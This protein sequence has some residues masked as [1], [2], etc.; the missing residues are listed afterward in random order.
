MAAIA[1][2]S[3][4]TASYSG[5]FVSASKVAPAMMARG[6]AAPEF[7]YGLPGGANILGEWDPAGFLE[8]KDKDTVFK[9]REAE[10]THGRVAM[11]ASLGFLVQEN[12]HPLFSGDGGPAIE[13]I[14]ALPPAL[15]FLMTLGIGAAEALR[16]QKGWANPYEK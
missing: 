2:L 14:P 4:E 12:F 9:Y 5:S 3:M 16:I 13:Q 6:K 15:W 8:G 11:L 10:L 1:M 7:A